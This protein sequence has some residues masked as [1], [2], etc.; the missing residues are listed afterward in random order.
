MRSHM[1]V[2]NPA[3]PTREPE[4]Q[5]E[6]TRSAQNPGK[7]INARNSS[8]RDLRVCYNASKM[9]SRTTHDRLYRALL[10]RDVRYEGRMLV[11]VT[12]TGI[13]CRLTCPARKP[14][15]SNCLFYREA[16]QCLE[17]GFRP[18][19][20]CRPLE[21]GAGAN[22]TC[23]LWVTIHQRYDAP[24]NDKLA[25]LF[26]HWQDSVAWATGCARWQPGQTSWM[27]SWTPGSNRPAA[28]APRAPGRG[29]SPNHLQRMENNQ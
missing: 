25:L 18:C 28:F 19:K 27:H 8:H 4:E 10:E 20:R 24:S 22:A 3:S 12:S 14:K 17:A 5:S 26:W 9:M 29:A 7:K 15:S 11:G 23:S 1:N 16:A 21:H 2:C 6:A 13:F